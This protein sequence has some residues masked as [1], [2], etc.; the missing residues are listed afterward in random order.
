MDTTLNPHRLD[1]HTEHDAL[2][3]TYRTTITITTTAE[4][5]RYGA[6]AYITSDGFA[7]LGLGPWEDGLDTIAAAVAHRTL[8]PNDH[9][10]EGTLVALA[11]GIIT[12]H[13]LT[14]NEVTHW[15]DPH[16]ELD[17]LLEWIT[18][19]VTDGWNGHTR[20]EDH[21]GDGYTCPRESW[22]T[23]ACGAFVWGIQQGYGTS[24]LHEDPEAAWSL[25][26]GQVQ[27]KAWAKGGAR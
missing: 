25:H 10:P 16:A 4:R 21:A 2:R 8:I 26:L 27:G 9:V 12:G 22:I 13:T 17:A 15:R 5:L 23:C 14:L 6:F 11:G 3:N 24:G 7:R 1:A 19:T 18:D 20:N